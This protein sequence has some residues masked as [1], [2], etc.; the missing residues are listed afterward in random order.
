MRFLFEDYSSR[1]RVGDNALMNLA[2][3]SRSLFI[4]IAF[5]SVVAAGCGGDDGG[6]EPG[7]DASP[8][9]G[10]GSADSQF[11]YL[12]QVTM[13][14]ISGGEPTCCKDFGA[15]SKAKIENDEDAVDNALAHLA[16]AIEDTGFIDFSFQDTIDGQLEAGGRV[17]LFGHDD[18][19]SDTD[20]F[21]LNGFFGEFEGDTTYAEASAGDGSFTIDP[22]SYD[23]SGNVVIRFDD[24]ALEGGELSTTE[25]TIA[26]T[27][28]MGDQIVTVPLH[29]GEL[30]GTATLSDD[31]VSY[32]D[33]TLAG[34]LLLEDLF[35]EMNEFFKSDACSCLGI[36]DRDVF[37]Y[38]NGWDST[39][40][41][42]DD[43]DG[44]NT[45]EEDSACNMAEGG[46]V[47][48]CS[49]LPPILVAEADIRTDAE[50]SDYQGLSIGFGFTGVPAQI[51]E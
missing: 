49:A 24:A 40:A 43:S 8:G 31:G 47:S 28:P 6:G 29:S 34:Y 41:Q 51:V 37:T 23:S 36:G 11:A 7:V 13:A 33:G 25:A 5:A 20:T 10:N 1:P 46:A 3:T 9:N 38:D 19:T 30:G 2:S 45:C 35:G 50:S 15:I 39:C 27:M 21:T 32:A 42:E 14:T 17:L 22:L 26:F 12:D 4:G 16:S 44:D 48:V 18:L